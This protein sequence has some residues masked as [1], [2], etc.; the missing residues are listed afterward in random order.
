[1]QSATQGSMPPP[2][3]PDLSRNQE[4]GAQW[5]EPPRLLPLHFVPK[6]STHSLPTGPSCEGGKGPREPGGRWLVIC[7][8][9]E[10]C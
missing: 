5:T 6:M 1:M 2:W 9:P 3:D 7:S 10:D 8:G 4:S